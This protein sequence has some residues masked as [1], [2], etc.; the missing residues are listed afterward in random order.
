MMSFVT[1]PP[2]LG[3]GRN[4]RV[5]GVWVDN[6]DGAAASPFRASSEMICP[7]VFFSLR[8]RAFAALR[9]SSAMSKVVLMHLMLMHLLR[10][11]SRAYSVR[12][13]SEGCLVEAF[14]LVVG[15]VGESPAGE[16]AC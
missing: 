13:E 6:V 14:E 11:S 8:A 10:K 1:T 2:R 5:S 12:L 16:R 4:P 9:T 15:D 7:A 3:K